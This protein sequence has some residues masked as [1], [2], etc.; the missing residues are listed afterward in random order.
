MVSLFY[1]FFTLWSFSTG[2]YFFNGVRLRL[3]FFILVYYILIEKG[4]YIYYG[5]RFYI[6]NSLSQQKFV[7]GP[8]L[9]K[10]NQR[11]CVVKKK[12]ISLPLLFFLNHVSIRRTFILMN[13]YSN[14][15]TSLW[16]F[17]Y[18]Y[19]LLWSMNSLYD[20]L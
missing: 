7:S 8:L 15:I 3:R 4:I 13:P 6:L 16:S 1:S 12:S 5:R 20:S 18:V 19:H 10:I 17:L 14:K 2:F 9:K 11:K